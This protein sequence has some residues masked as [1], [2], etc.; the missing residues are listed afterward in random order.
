MEP[1]LYVPVALNCCVWPTLIG[2]PLEFTVRKDGVMVCANP[3][4]VKVRLKRTVTVYKM[5]FRGICFIPA[6]SIK[7]WIY[8]TMAADETAGDIAFPLAGA[9]T[10]P[11]SLLGEIVTHETGFDL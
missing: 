4:L 3:G 11:L 10:S 8:V 1:S 7:V 2:K 5:Y 6:S 9:H